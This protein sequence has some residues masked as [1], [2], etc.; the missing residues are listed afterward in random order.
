[1]FIRRNKQLYLRL[2]LDRFYKGFD[3]YEVLN[4]CELRR[5]HVSVKRYGEY[6]E[7]SNIKD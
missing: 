7:K 4:N 5:Y 6:K 3:L 1:M 2:M